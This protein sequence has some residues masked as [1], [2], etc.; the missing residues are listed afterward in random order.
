MFQ[1]LTKP[2]LGKTWEDARVYLRPT[3]FVDRPHELDEHCLR[4]ADTMVWFA[5]WHVSLRD[6]GAVKSAVVP[7]AELDGWIA[8]MPDRLA[9]AAKAQRAGVARPRGNL[10]LGER[11]VRLGEPQ[12]MGILNVTP[13]SFSD[14][15]KHVDAAAAAEAGFAMGAAGA[16]IVDVGGESTRPG[17]PLIWEGDEIARIEGV[18]AAL[19]KGGVAVSIDTRKAAVMEAALAAG[20]HLVNDISAL[21]Y[22]DR[23]MEVVVQAGC[24]VVLMHAPSAKSDPHADGT[25]AHVLFDVYD[26]LAERVAA[27]VAAGIGRA[28]IIVDPGLGFGKGVGENLTLVNGLALFHTLGCPIL[29]G[30]SRKRMIGAL[31]NEAPADQRLG[32]TV[33][34]HYQA[35]AHGAQLLRVHDI[36]EN[37]QALRVWRGLRDAALTA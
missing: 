36:A 33:A 10:Q 5:A 26:M 29:F 11:T 14:G 19:A 22:D 6:D 28:K 32:G 25:Y 30:A 8:A 23:A 1:P 20:A 37:R 9:E 27:C 34:L 21:R 18:V 31:D 15:G 16:A 2:D 3:C 12:L 17:A 35:A 24:P 4:I 13:D 7:V